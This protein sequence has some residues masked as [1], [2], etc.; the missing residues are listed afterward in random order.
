[1][2]GDLI[3]LEAIKFFRELVDKRIIY[4]NQSR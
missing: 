4:C 1:M 2:I 3:D